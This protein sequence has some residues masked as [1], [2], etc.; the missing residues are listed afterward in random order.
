MLWNRWVAWR[1]FTLPT[2]IAWCASCCSWA[3]RAMAAGP[4]AL[5]SGERGSEWA[6]RRLL[7]SAGMRAGEGGTC[8]VPGAEIELGG[9]TLY[10]GNSS[11]LGPSGNPGTAIN[12]PGVTCVTLFFAFSLRFCRTYLFKQPLPVERSWVKDDL[13]M[14]S[15][16]AHFILNLTLAGFKAY[17]DKRLKAKV[18]L[19][20]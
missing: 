8:S 17:L 5:S 11:F 3:D 18:V 4:L 14:G 19:V 15:F 2:P 10:I 16:H 20:Y 1:E 12:Q 13:F 6:A 9:C 7:E